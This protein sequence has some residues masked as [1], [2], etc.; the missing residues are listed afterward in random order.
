MS[1]EERVL[2]LLLGLSVI[3][4]A[5]AILTSSG[6]AFLVALFAAAFVAFLQGRR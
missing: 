3:V 6:V 4:C 1:T 5:L 2:W